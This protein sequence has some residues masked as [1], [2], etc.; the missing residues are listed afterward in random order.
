MTDYN[1]LLQKADIIAEQYHKGQIDKAGA[2]YIAH[3]RRVSEHCDGMKA[4]IVALLHDTIEDTEITSDFLL[5]QGFPQE[6]VDAVLSVTRLPNESYDDFIT[7]A[8]LN[9]I[10]REVKIADLRDNM[11]ITRLDYPLQEKDFERLNKYLKAYK[12]LFV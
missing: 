2:D 8:S 4:K 5:D 11:N 3:P 12:R 10:G 1:Y 9:P 7:R 6:I